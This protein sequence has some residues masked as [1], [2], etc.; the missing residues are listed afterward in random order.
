M[1]GQVSLNDLVNLVGV[2]SDA[3]GKEANKISNAF[4]KF[5]TLEVDLLGKKNRTSIQN[6]KARTRTKSKLSID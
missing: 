2:K 6:S 3:L 5:Q 4:S 1:A